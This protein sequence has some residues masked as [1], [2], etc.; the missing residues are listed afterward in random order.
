MSKVFI[1]TKEGIEV[2]NY[3]YGFRL[4]TTLFDSMEFNSKKG[5]RHCTQTINPKNN[6]MNKPKKSTYYP[7]LVRYYDENKHIKSNSFSLDS[8]ES[9]N[10]TALFLSKN[11]ELFTNEE[12]EYF[13]ILFLS[14]IKVC[15]YA[16][17]AYC[18]TDSELL[19][20][21]VEEQVKLLTSN[22]KRF[23]INTFENITFDVERINATKVEG[24]QPFKRVSTLTA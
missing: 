22:I 16:Q 2:P 8:F 18:G 20:P 7:I 10:R 6:Q 15:V 19:L 3:P 11:I 17:V 1:A 21:L 9:M 5:Y 14:N 4:R 12:R 24:Y 23:D 13:H